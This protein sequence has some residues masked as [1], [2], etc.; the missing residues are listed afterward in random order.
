MAEQVSNIRPNLRWHW[1]H[2]LGRHAAIV[3]PAIALMYLLGTGS[4][5]SASNFSELV[6]FGVRSRPSFCWQRLYESQLSSLKA[7]IEYQQLGIKACDILWQRR[8]EPLDQ[9]LELWQLAQ[10]K[11]AKR[12]IRKM[13][14]PLANYVCVILIR[15]LF[16]FWRQS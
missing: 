12:L 15:G 7:F 4:L 5:F 16:G 14:Y 2:S 13:L 10:K 6:C 9:R 11:E 3:L 8:K 1:T